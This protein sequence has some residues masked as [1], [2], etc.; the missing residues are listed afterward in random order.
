MAD[1]ILGIDYGERRVGLALAQNIARLPRPYK[2]LQNDETLLAALRDIIDTE[3]VGQV[4]VGVPRGIDGALTEQSRACE[5]F[6]ARLAGFVAVPV[7]TTDETLSSIEAETYLSGARKSF[8]KADIDAA[9]AA[10][11]LQR[12]FEGETSEKIGELHG[13]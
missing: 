12:Y 13:I 9:A 10:V 11:I 6:A 4:V 2:T 3:D 1:Y 7:T 8:Q 5:A